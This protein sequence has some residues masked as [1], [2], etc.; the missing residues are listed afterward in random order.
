MSKDIV[1]QVKGEIILAA[2][3]QHLLELI[4]PEWQ[5]RQ[6]I[7]RVKRLAAVDPSSACQRLFN[8]AIQDL[9]E[10]IVVAGIDI[11]ASV[12]NEFQLPPIRK[13]DDVLESYPSQ[14]LIDLSYRIGF[15]SRPE[16]RRLRRCY[17][18]RR[19]LE[20]EDA[21]YEATVEDCLYI[22]NTCINCVLSREAIP[23]LRVEDIKQAVESDTASTLEPHFVEDFLNAP[24][25]RQIDIYKYLIS[26]ASEESE[27]QIVQSN[28]AE[29]MRRLRS[30]IRTSAKLELA[31]YYGDRT[32][33]YGL[34]E[35][36]AKVAQ[37]AGILALLPRRQRDS[38]FQT[39]L[40]DFEATGPGWRK[41]EAH[42]DLFDRFE[43]VGGFEGCSDDIQV[44]FLRW[45][46]L[47]FLGE[48]GNYGQWG[49]NRSVFFS[50]RAAPRIESLLSEGV[51]RKVLVKYLE[52]LSQD[53]RI[54]A[55]CGYGPIQKRF[56]SLKDIADAEK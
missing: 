56:D 18:I 27:V 14:K 11:A 28:A 5:Q 49:S 34:S 45:M 42:C 12:A 33:K 32:K 6:L 1:K 8:A 54:Q 47:C 16:W 35:R 22:F 55:A 17:E 38:Y 3:G 48:P 44:R 53:E 4:R 7:E 41:W 15:F 50:D 46:I 37:A 9:R 24:D 13:K 30:K 10:K 36:D 31:K 21:E 23:L 43:D 19:D 2:D 52:E 20:H 29:V 39:V 25:P 40:E 51:G 26:K